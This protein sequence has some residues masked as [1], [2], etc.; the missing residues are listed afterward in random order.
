METECL[1][2]TWVERLPQLLRVPMYC[3]CFATALEEGNIFLMKICEELEGFLLSLQPNY[4]G[5]KHGRSQKGMNDTSG[6][7]RQIG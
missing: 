4:I 2:S 5:N 6:Q 1:H 3:S 7:Q